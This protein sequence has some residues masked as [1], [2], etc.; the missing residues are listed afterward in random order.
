MKDMYPK[1]IYLDSKYEDLVEGGY[2]IIH[3][4]NK[5]GRYNIKYVRD[6]KEEPAT[7]KCIFCDKD[8]VIVPANARGVK[9]VCDN[10]YHTEC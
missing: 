8:L 7:L 3:C 10:C 4:Y 9:V 1:T 2:G 5:R 6:M